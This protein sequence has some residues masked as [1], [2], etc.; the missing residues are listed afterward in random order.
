[1]KWILVPLVLVW[2]VWFYLGIA[3]AILILYPF[4]FVTSLKAEWYPKFFVFARVWAWMVLLWSGLW[5]KVYWDEKPDKNKVYIICANHTSMIDIMMTL[6]LFSNCFLFIGKKEL[7]K[8]PLFG[9]FYRKTNLLVDR[10]SLRSRRDVFDRAGVKVDEGIS[11]CIYPEG[12][13]PKYEV[14]L[15]PFKN[16]AFRLAVEKNVSVIPV[17]YLD[18]KRHLPFNFFKGHPGVC[19][20]VVRPFLS[21]RDN[22]DDSEVDRLR[23]ECYQVIHDTL[24][25]SQKHSMVLNS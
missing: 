23:E 5:P 25:G 8:F 2:R 17:V 24:I 1:M 18:N 9:Y 14:D 22:N 12:G 3:M 20:A 10:S 21:P 16:G 6:A 15:A 4:I 13:V 7:T 11:V 19:R